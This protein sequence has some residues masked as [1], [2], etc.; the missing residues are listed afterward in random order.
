MTM[1]TGLA[2]IGGAMCLL[3]FLAVAVVVIVLLA[4]VV[5][6]SKGQGVVFKDGLT[7]D[8]SEIV[9]K[10]VSDTFTAQKVADTLIKVHTALST[11]VAKLPK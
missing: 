4:Q 2:T 11:A 6:K 10:V 7:K 3:A 1:A 8:E 5:T 9:M